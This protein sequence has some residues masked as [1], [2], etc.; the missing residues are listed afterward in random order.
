MQV[1]NAS[2]KMINPYDLKDEDFSPKIIAQ[3]LSRVCRFWSQTSE[4][5]SVAQHCLVMET[6]FDDKEL[7]KWAIMH[8][9]FEGLTGMDIP[10]PI[11]HS[12]K[13]K[14]YREA[15]DKAL[16]QAANLFN[17]IYPIP[18]E[19]KTMD[20]RL[21]VTEALKF[22]NT[23]NYDWTKLAKPLPLTVIKTPMNMKEAEIAFLRK[24]YE[25]F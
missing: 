10:T 14:S 25:L 5:Y 4:F 6:L 21:M 20:K 7:K 16:E 18:N 11:K 8:E 3:T 12:T 1:M 22:M 9:V 17:L 13:M 2:G 23:K 15:E 19:I 24:G